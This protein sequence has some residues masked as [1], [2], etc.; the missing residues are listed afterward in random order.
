MLLLLLRRRWLQS[1]RL[2][3]EVCHSVLC[4]MKMISGMLVRWE[5]RK[6]MSSIFHSFDKMWH[7]IH[8]KMM[9]MM[10]RLKFLFNVKE[11]RR[12]NVERAAKGCE[13]RGCDE[14]AQN[15]FGMVWGAFSV[16]WLFERMNWS[17]AVMYDILF[18]HR[19]IHELL[20]YLYYLHLFSTLHCFNSCFP[21]SR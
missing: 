11:W 20:L 12:M 17:V 2:F 14:R 6:R 19:H 9:M 15:Q 18:Q 10:M 3:I 8:H 4:S 21:S 7:I 1:K 13:R 5:N 16:G